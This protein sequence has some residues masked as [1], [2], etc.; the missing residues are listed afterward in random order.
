MH[1]KPWK[2]LN[3]A[4]H[5][6]KSI[7][8]IRKATQQW[9]NTNKMRRS[10]TYCSVIGSNI[11]IEVNK[12]ELTLDRIWKYSRRLGFSSR[13]RDVLARGNYEKWRK[14]SWSRNPPHQWTAKKDT[15]CLPVYHHLLL[16]GLFI[17]W[18]RL[19]DEKPKRRE[20]F[21]IQSKVRKRLFT[22]E[23]TY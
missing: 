14:L 19:L 22:T 7:R 8:L 1:H 6:F 23:R 5:N 15:N 3:S 21:Q 12:F 9:L 17:T 11:H 13:S 20:D 18:P 2:N 10:S 16:T 4:L